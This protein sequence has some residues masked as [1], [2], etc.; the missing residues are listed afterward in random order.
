MINARPSEETSWTLR[1]LGVC[2]G[3]VALS[4]VVLSA[5]AFFGVTAIPVDARPVVSPAGKYM[6]IISPT[7]GN[8]SFQEPLALTRSGHFAF[9]GGPKGSWMKTNAVITMNGKDDHV[10]FVFEI[11]QVR[12]ELGTRFQKGTVT[13]GGHPFG[14]WYASR[15]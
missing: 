2:S 3:L 13:E 7:G 4:V 15:V 12:Q 11:S 10:Q 8:S 6:A 5:S 1:H 9:T 14:K